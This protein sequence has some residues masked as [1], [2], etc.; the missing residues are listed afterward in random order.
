VGARPNFIKIAPVIEALG[1]NPVSLRTIL[2]HTG[3]HY[4]E[5]MADNF[6]RQLC[7][8]EPD[9]DLGVGSGSHAAQTAEIMLRFE[10]VLEEVNPTAVLVV[11]DVN[12]TLACAVVAA[13][14][15]IAV[16]HVEAGLPSYDRS[17]PEEINRVLTDQMAD[18]LFTTEKSAEQNLYKGSRCPMV[19]RELG[20]TN[21]SSKTR[22]CQ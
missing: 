2:V 4:D 13:K 17:M 18:L 20:G 8:A 15:S 3:Q 5:E 7:I 1:A 19:A 11:G 22:R 14:K 21:G 16:I 6:F 9:V 10:P 12:S